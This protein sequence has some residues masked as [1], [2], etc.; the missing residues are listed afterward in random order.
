V[1][2]EEGERKVQGW[3]HLPEGNASPKGGREQKKGKKAND[4]NYEKGG[5]K[6]NESK[7]KTSGKKHTRGGL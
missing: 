1:K 5:G 3:G 4:R 6:T 7:K 2:A